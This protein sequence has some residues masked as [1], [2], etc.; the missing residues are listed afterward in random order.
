MRGAGFSLEIGVYGTTLRTPIV[1]LRSVLARHVVAGGPAVNS[2]RLDYL[3]EWATATEPVDHRA[4]SDAI[5]ASAH[6]PGVRLS[7]ARS[8]AVHAALVG[9]EGRRRDLSVSFDADLQP[10]RV[11]EL[12]YKATTLEGALDS[13]G[14]FPE[15]RLRGVYREIDG[16][17]PGSVAPSPPFSRVRPRPVRTDLPVVAR[18]ARR[19]DR[20]GRDVPRPA[21]R[22]D[23]LP[24]R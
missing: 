10:A 21:A 4:L 9:P 16:R 15:S 7:N 18:P 22:A 12:S 5:E 1:D 6:T 23:E 8:D 11:R 3:V 13:L 14:E 24:R 19:S 20:V 2:Y 17:R